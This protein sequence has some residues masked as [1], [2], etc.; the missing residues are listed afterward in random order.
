MSPDEFDEFLSKSLKNG[1][2]KSTQPINEIEQFIIDKL[3]RKR[4]DKKRKQ[5]TILKVT[6]IVLV[7]LAFS[8]T[9]LF[10]GPLY[11]FKEQLIH[12][13]IDLGKN[14][15]INF[16]DNSHHPKLPDKMFEEIAAIQ[17]DVPFDIL[18]PRYLPPEFGFSSVEKNPHDEQCKIVM[19]FHSVDALLRLT[20]TEIS[21]NFAV[22]ININAQRGNSE[23]IQV[24]ADE[25]NMITFS[26][27]SISLTWI[28]DAHILCELSGNVNAEQ[29]IAIAVSM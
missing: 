10:P 27:G 4:A 5:R 19:S 13:I 26:D 23:K 9:V 17:P 20:Q 25:G 12:T 21:D 11:A 3:A 14:I 16:T 29:A 8:G 24:G 28:T 22:S 15:N 18:I 7:L 2:I 1:G 6:V